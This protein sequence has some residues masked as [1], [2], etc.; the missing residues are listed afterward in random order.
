MIILTIIAQL[1]L[2]I[3]FFLL[4]IKLAIAMV[5]GLGYVV[6]FFLRLTKLKQE[7]SNNFDHLLT[8]K[9]NNQLADQLLLNI[10]TGV[11]EVLALPFF[12]TKHYQT[13]FQFS[14]LEHL[15]EALKSNQGAIMLTMHAGNYELVP[16]ALASLGYKVNSILR[17]EHGGLAD[18]LTKCR[19]SA[20]VKIINIL[21][22]NL[23]KESLNILN[24]NELVG[25]LADTGAQDGRNIEID[26][27]EIWKLNFFENDN[28]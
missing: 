11:F 7:V 17:M 5:N 18:I 24:Q 19:A 23:Y 28:L 10:C 27:L 16:S 2:R 15:T 25:F 13:L 1:I 22:S 3:A 14:G 9:N 4:P 20:G 12:R 6:Y 8:D 26:F 21:E